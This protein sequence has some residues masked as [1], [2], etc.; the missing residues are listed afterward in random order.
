MLWL[1]VALLG[2]FP[3]ETVAQIQGDRD[4]D[5]RHG[6]VSGGR[7]LSFHCWGCGF[8]PWLGELRSLEL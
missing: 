6:M 4:E 5:V 2:T 8:S 7:T 3:R 1:R